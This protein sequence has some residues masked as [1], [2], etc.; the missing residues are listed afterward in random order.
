M[1]A[2]KATE[3]TLILELKN[4]DIR[5]VTIPNTWKVTFGNVIPYQGKEARHG[6]CR[7]ALR[8]YEGNKENLRAVMCDVVSFREDTIQIMEKRTKVQRQAAQKHTN[9]GMKDVVVEARITE[10]VNPDKE[11]GTEN[12]VPEEFL[13][14]PGA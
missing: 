5:K 12:D 10:W 9:N 11:E 4:G 13:K 8:F 1:V 7:I 14:L 6:E 2:A 3:R